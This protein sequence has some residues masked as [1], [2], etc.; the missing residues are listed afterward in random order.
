[1]GCGVG[2]REQEESNQQAWH[3]D[4][5]RAQLNFCRWWPFVSEE[6][7]QQ[8]GGQV[9]TDKTPVFILMGPVLSTSE[10]IP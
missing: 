3:D 2:V 7:P 6:S 10:E 5:L 4:L 9:G 1:M 8:Y